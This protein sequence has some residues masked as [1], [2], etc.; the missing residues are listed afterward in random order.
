MASSRIFGE[1]IG[2]LRIGN[3]EREAWGN[4]VQLST[5]QHSVKLDGSDPQ[6]LRIKVDPVR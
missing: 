2:K 6:P 1:G 5:E 3:P 4:V